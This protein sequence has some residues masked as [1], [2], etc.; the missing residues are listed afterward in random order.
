[1]S[2][3]GCRSRWER[4]SV[5]VAAPAP[6]RPDVVVQHQK[7]LEQDDSFA[8]ASELP[9]EVAQPASPS[10]VEPEGLGEVLLR[11]LGGIRAHEIVRRDGNSAALEVDPGVVHPAIRSVH[12]TKG[13]AESAAA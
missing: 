5:G 11:M 6:E 3:T 8:L 9:E 2:A 4:R 1:M 7:L 12:L 10:D 13:T